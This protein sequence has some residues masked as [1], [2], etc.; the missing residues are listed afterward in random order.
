MNNSEV[1]LSIC[2]PTYNRA[3]VLNRTL[4]SIVNQD[5]FKNTNEIEVVI[6]DNK[7]NDSTA[8]VSRKFSALFPEKIRYYRNTENIGAEKNFEV[9]LSRG[10]GKFLK[11]HNDTLL[12]K[13]GSLNEIIK[14]IKATDT[15]KPI[16][17]LTNGSKKN[18]QQIHICNNIDEFVNTASFYSTW[19]GGFGIWKKDFESI[20]NFSLNADL[21]LIQTDILLR[22]LATG[23]RA[24]ILTDAYF[25]SI[26]PENKGGYNIA[27]VFGKNY[28]SILKKY[29]ATG[30]LSSKTYQEEKITLLKNHIIPYYFGEN[31]FSKTGFFKY[32]EDFHG[33]Q[34]FYEEIEKLINKKADTLSF[35]RNSEL[36]SNLKNY[37]RHLNQHNET[38]LVKISG[39]INLNDIKI[40]S[41]TYGGLTIFSFGNENEKLTIGNYTSIADDVSFLLGGNHPYQG[42]S[43]F[44]FL[45]KYF[46]TPEAATKGQIK[47]GDDVWIGYR[48]TI[49][50]GVTIGQGAIIAAGS[51]V[52]NDIPPYSIA[53]GNPAKVIK[54]RFKEELINKLKNL[55]FSKLTDEL[56]LKN[57]NILYEPLTLENVDDILRNLKETL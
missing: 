28:L 12:I 33:D 2:I 8:D 29:V 46:N 5:L 11:L 34:L 1:I 56:I 40:G 42:F 24:I 35:N 44:P 45:A 19:I 10:K 27:E 20:E 16:I 3:E 17:F 6:S 13:N 43:T 38:F 53:G 23:K 48:S 26:N 31:N 51:V 4:E 7:S 47:I 14:V 39:P 22:L 36:K 41:K 55:D 57:K 25:T 9:S 37:W 54:Y 15:E 52:T 49:L 32:M 50:S 30:D 21:K 18:N